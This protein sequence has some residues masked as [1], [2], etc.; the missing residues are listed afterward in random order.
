MKNKKLEIWNFFISR[1]PI[2]WLTLIAIIIAGL[3]SYSSMPKVIQPEVNPPFV[4][5]ITALPGANPEDTES[6][7]T[8]PLEEQIANISDIKTLSSGSGS[9]TSSIFIEFESGVDIDEAKQEVKDAVDR[10]K[11]ELPD[12]ATDPLVV[13]A[14]SNTFSIVTIS[15]AG[16]RPI[17]ELTEI[18][19]NISDELKREINDISDTEILGGQEKFIKITVNQKKAE[20]FKIDLNTV[21]GLISSSNSNLPVGVITSDMINYSVRIDNRFQTVED[22]R[23]TPLIALGDQNSTPLLVKDIA[24]VEEAYPVRSV[25]NKISINGEESLPTVSIQIYNKEDSDIIAIANQTR[26]LLDEMELPTDITL[27][28][29]NDNSV[30][31]SEELGNLTTNGIFTTILITIIL[32]LALGLRKGIISGLSIPVIFLFAFTIMSIQGLS[33]NTLSLFSLVIALGLM[34]DTTIVIMEGIHENIKNGL[35]AKES[36]IESVN[37]YKWPLIAGTFTTIFAFFPM[38][39]VSGILGE[40]L[41]TLPITIS[42]ALFGSLFISLTI[43]PSLASKF[44]REGKEKRTV[45]ILEPMFEKIGKKFRSFIEKLVASRKMRVITILTAITLFILSLFLPFL[46]ILK[47]EMWPS[48]DQYYFTV[49]IETTKGTDISKTTEITEMVEEELY[50]IPEVSNFLT[51]IGSSASVAIT[52]DPFFQGGSMDSNVA[53]LTVNLVNKDERERSSIE[54]ADEL[55]EKFE[56]YPYANIEVRELSEG[57]PSDAAVTVRITG[58]SY[59]VIRD[60]ADQVKRETENIP[61]TAN[62]RLDLEQGLNEFKFSLD[63]DKLAYHG[64]NFLQVAGTIRSIIQGADA[65]TIT[66]DNE[67]LDI[68]LRYDLN[69]VNS[70][71][72]ISIHDIENFEIATPKGY[73][74]TLGQVGEY[75]LAPSLSSIARED[76]KRIIKVLSDTTANGS[77][78]EITRQLQAKVAMMDIPNGYEIS[79]GGDLEEIDRSMEELFFKAMPTGILL[80]AF[81]LVLMFNSF[82]LPLIILMTLPL[83]MIGV[84]PGLKLINLPLSFPVFLGIVA[85]V[86]IVVNDA[87]VLIDRI[88]KNRES[89][90]SFTEAIAEAANARLQPIMMTSITTIIG[91]LPLAI[92]NK[93]WAGLGFS[94]VF[95]LMASTVLTLIVVPTLYYMLEYRKAKRNGEVREEFVEV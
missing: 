80:I 35:S 69:E 14:E 4:S 12:D 92:T 37:T 36:A 62:T 7:I 65:D 19:E 32:F 84:F 47:I 91:I 31:I 93:F 25:I 15:I 28:I 11:N 38:L 78:V 79:F 8:R 86:G 59:D 70:R 41:K 56:N 21:A 63:K 76:Q 3:I 87:I 16:E 29:T 33:L 55:R 77:A 64:L 51:I 26:D 54:I 10:V 52:E 57:P 88:N 50:K 42:A 46:G 94:L 30:F 49:F 53:N 66:I 5:V 75:E 34:V 58:D 22:I 73:S 82:K 68:I 1:R 83:S 74:I 39:L 44:V 2:A 43:A 9:G 95:G 23:N 6:L 20:G 85:L 67:D 27:S 71:T 89:D 45:S 81:T 72:N 13:K 48:T 61:G 90:L 24:T 17:Y 40:F 18:A 60:L